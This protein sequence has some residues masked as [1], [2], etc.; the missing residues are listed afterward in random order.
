MVYRLLR[1]LGE[2]GLAHAESSILQKNVYA[3][4]LSTH[5]WQCFS[6][7]QTAG[8]PQAKECFGLTT[9]SIRILTITL[10]ISF[11]EHCA[12][13]RCL[14]CKISITTGAP[15]LHPRI[16]HFVLLNCTEFY[17]S[18]I[19]AFIIQSLNSTTI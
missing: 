3:V 7:Q 17:I 2:L 5:H 16:P 9:A 19:I 13:A 4:C 12:S 10:L 11:H 1:F 15:I 18:F 6:E 14:F 8:F